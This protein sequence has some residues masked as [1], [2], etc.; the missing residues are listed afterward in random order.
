VK[1]K[2]PGGFELPKRLLSQLQRVELERG[3]DAVAEKNDAFLMDADSN[4]P[5]YLTW[6]GHVIIDDGGNVRDATED[7]KVAAVVAGARKTGLTVLLNLLPPRAPNAV[8]CHS[9]EGGR[10]KT[11]THVCPECH[12]RGWNA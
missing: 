6:D 12:G 1:Q 4:L 3:R 2:R 5:S 10:W 8:T 9:C 7:E 11:E